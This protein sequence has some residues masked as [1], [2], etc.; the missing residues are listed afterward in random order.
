[1]VTSRLEQATML[2]IAD[3]IQCWIHCVYQGNPRRRRGGSL[4][5]I[6]RER[7]IRLSTALGS[8][9]S[10][11]LAGRLRRRRRQLRRRGPPPPAW[12]FGWR[13]LRR[14]LEE[15]V[16]WRSQDGWNGH[17]ERV[18]G[19]RPGVAH[20]FK[21]SGNPLSWSTW[22]TEISWRTRRSVLIRAARSPTRMAISP[23]RATARSS[24]RPMAPL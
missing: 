6:S 21:D 20:T 5:E 4:G 18:T 8:W 15:I 11:R 9:R 10:L 2:F 3:K 13:W 16:H 12:R 14:R 1:M 19:P 22:T 17:R 23:A 24:I 7:F